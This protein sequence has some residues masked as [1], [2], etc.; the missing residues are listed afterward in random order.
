MIKI[1]HGQELQQYLEQQHSSLEQEIINEEKNRLLNVDETSYVEYLL[2]K[3]TIELLNFHWE[4][5]Y[6]T[7]SEQPISGVRYSILNGGD[8]SSVRKQVVTYH[9]PFSGPQQFL[10][11]QPSTR[12]LWAINIILDENQSE[13][14]F[15][16]SNLENN[17]E[18]L[19]LEAKGIF[20][21]IKEQANYLTTQITTY[22]T[23]LRKSALEAVSLRK[24]EL[25]KQANLLVSLGV[26]IKKTDKV[27]DTFL[28]P[29]HKKK[30]MI[31]K[32]STSNSAY[33]PEPEL[34]KKEYQ[35]ILKTCQDFGMAMERAPSTYQGKGEEALRD[36]FLMLLNPHFDSVTGETFNKSGKT[37]ILI[38]HEGK[39]VFIAECKFW[40]G[41]KL[42]NETIDQILSYLTWRDSKAAIIY[43]VRNKNLQPVLDNITEAT[44]SHP[45]FVRNNGNTSEAWFNYHFHLLNDSSRGVELAILVFHLSDSLK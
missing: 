36:Y 34:G 37:D 44:P 17:A 3:Y 9:L 41:E 13:I 31:Q 23:T 38:R 32:P 19:K 27:S 30:I 14:T 43:F 7:D 6:I 2:N 4:Y 8:N 29:I 12:I 25:L 33:T 35:E 18:K 22:N 39:N 11:M 26:P 24:T 5:V 15:D 21:K 1:F 42:H 16:I 20:D 45:S 28:V 10:Q 40:G